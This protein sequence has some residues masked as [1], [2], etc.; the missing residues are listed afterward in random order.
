MNRAPELEQTLTALKGHNLLAKVSRIVIG[1]S[2]IVV[3]LG[4][5]EPK[6]EKAPAA[7]KVA[8]EKAA[9]EEEIMYGSAGA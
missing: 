3:D 7:D 5:G 4:G 1:E 6:A 8:L 9:L 2:G